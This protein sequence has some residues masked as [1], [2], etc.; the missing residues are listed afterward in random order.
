MSTRGNNNSIKGTAKCNKVVSFAALPNKNPITLAYT[1]FY[2][3]AIIYLR[4]YKGNIYIYLF[5]E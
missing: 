2:N 3:I 1:N 4:V 5:A